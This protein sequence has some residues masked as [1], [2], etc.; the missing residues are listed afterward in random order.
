[1]DHDP[2]AES[3]VEID[4]RLMVKAQWRTPLLLW[5]VASVLL[6]LLV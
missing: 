2:N 4:L 1:M 5:L 3:D 6:P